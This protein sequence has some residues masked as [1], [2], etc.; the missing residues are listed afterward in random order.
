ME[1]MENL[2]LKWL[3]I[4]LFV[5]FATAIVLVC[6]QARAA[7]PECSGGFVEWVGTYPATGGT[8]SYCTPSVGATGVVYP[9]DGPPMSCFVLEAGT[10]LSQRDGLAPGS[11]QIVS[12]PTL[13][14]GH[15]LELYCLNQAGVGE[16]QGPIPVDFPDDQPGRI[17]LVPPA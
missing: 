6:S 17:Y 12:L 7:D 14:F 2:G 3:E 11:L 16:A 9:G 10:I 8:L 1:R 15:S 4:I 5:M 13:R